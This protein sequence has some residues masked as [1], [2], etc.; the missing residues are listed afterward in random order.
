V[1]I[2]RIEKELGGKK[3]NTSQHPVAYIKTSDG[4]KE[5][6]SKA[7]LRYTKCSETAQGG[8]KCWVVSVLVGIGKDERS[9]LKED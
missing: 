1:K 9:T 4:G 6:V 5:K 3:A 7:S 8:K 2:S